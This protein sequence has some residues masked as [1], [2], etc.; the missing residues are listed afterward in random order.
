MPSLLNRE[1][2]AVDLRLPLALPE[3]VFLADR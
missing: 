2:L 1:A 3:C